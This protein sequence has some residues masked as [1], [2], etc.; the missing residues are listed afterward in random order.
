MI[1]PVLIS[2]KL[3]RSIDKYKVRLVSKGYAQQQDIYYEGTFAPSAKLIA[4]RKLLAL[5]TQF[6]W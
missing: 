5:V 3:D 1:G 6:G 4:M 2:L